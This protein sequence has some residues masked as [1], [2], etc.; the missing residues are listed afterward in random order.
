MDGLPGLKRAVAFGKKDHVAP[1]KKMVGPMAPTRYQ[2][3]CGVPIAHVLLIALFAFLAGLIG[4]FYA[5]DL[6]HFIEQ[7][8]NGRPLNLKNAANVTHVPPALEGLTSLWAT[9]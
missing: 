7:R 4:A 6:P 5:P 1:L 8:I 3:G 2:T 9:K